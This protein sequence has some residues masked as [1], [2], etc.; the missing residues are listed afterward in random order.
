MLHYNV[1][2]QRHRWK[3][4]NQCSLTVHLSNPTPMLLFLELHENLSIV[5]TARTEPCPLH[6]YWLFE[7]SE[8]PDQR[9]EA[10]ITDP[11]GRASK[12]SL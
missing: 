2:Q 12:M 7:H 4:C 11:E 3:E 1:F 5:T 8:A 9:R 10:P 6:S